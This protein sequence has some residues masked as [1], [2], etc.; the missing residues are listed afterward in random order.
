MGELGALYSDGTSLT[1]QL[2]G[3]EPVTRVFDAVHEFAAEVEHFADSLIRNTRPLH[4]HKEG[5]EV[6]GIIL[7]AYESA[8]TKTVAPVLRAG[9]GALLTG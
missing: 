2:R 9:T 3:Q 1:F 8:R 5:I 4:T 6:L 7:A